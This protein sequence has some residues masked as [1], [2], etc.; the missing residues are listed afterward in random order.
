M[1]KSRTRPAGISVGRALRI[2][3][4]FA[5]DLLR[6]VV[7]A[8][9]AVHGDGELPEI[10]L[11]LQAIWPREGRFVVDPANGAPVAIAIDAEEP[12]RLAALHEIGHFFS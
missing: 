11:T 10:E 4:G 8:I 1:D 5:H 7:A 12:S 6:E 2:R 9:D 3:S